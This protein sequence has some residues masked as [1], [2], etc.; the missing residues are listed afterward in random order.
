MTC[1][2]ERSQLQNKAFAMGILRSKLYELE[3][4]KRAAELDE[5][6]G[7]KS[8]IAWG[9]QIRS[10][11][12]YPYQMVKDLRTNEETGNTDA[13]LTGGDLDPFIIAYH[14]WVVGGG[15]A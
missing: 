11:V 13:V 9:N 3:L 1:Q 6:R 10:Y 7:P 14:R 4:E 15:T 8:E 5:L 12:L 2:N